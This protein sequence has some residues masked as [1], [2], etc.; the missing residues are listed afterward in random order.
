[1]DTKNIA[2]FISTFSVLF[3]LF[4][5]FF[6]FPVPSPVSAAIV[7]DATSPLDCELPD[8]DTD[9][10]ECITQDVA[11]NQGGQTDDCTTCP[12]FVSHPINVAT[13]SKYENEEDYRSSD[14]FPLILSRFYNSVDTNLSTLGIGWRMAY[15]RVIAITSSVN[16][17]EAI[18]DDGKILSFTLSGGVWTPD[19]DVNSKLDLFPDLSMFIILPC[20]K[21]FNHHKK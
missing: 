11:K 3:F 10:D 9:G 16:K 6:L 5:L 19:G 17:V 2:K 21:V 20:N 12:T 15:S 7:I 14:P 1:M 18:R 4:F 8:G 13:G